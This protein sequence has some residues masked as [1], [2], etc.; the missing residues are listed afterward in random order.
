MDVLFNSLAALT[1]TGGGLSSLSGLRAFLPLALVGLISRYGLFGA[2]DLDDT[3][4]A[5][6]Q[7]PWVIA[8]LLALAVFEIVADKVPVVD[9]LQDVVAGPLRILAGATHAAKGIVRPGATAASGGT[10][11]PFISFLEDLFTFFGTF[12]VILLPILG[13]LLVL[14]VLF[15]IYRVRRR[16][17]RKYKGLRILKE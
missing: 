8:I 7:N 16:R 15:V 12:L 6:L 1:A 9:S 10:A 11:N 4:F 2:F 17:R 14:F 5:I 13:L 3:P